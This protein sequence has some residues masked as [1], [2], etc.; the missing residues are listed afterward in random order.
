[1]SHSQQIL[2]AVPLTAEAF[3]PYGEVIE[4]GG[5][6]IMINEGRCKRFTDLAPLI[7]E[8]DGTIGISMFLSEVQSLPYTCTLMERHPHGS[9]CF[10]PMEGAQTLYIVALDADGAPT[11][12]HAF[13]AA[14]HQAVNIAKNTWHGVLTPVSGTGLY[15]VVDRIGGSP[16]L[17]EVTLERPLLV[18]LN[19]V[20]GTVQRETRNG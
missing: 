8:G 19:N 13:L 16:N 7:A 17:Q 4:V 20:S 5:A 14:G 2:T 11:A 6:H 1:V 18:D 15:A 12:P 9:Q 10:V 3:A